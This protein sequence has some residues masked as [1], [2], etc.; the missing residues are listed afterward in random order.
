MVFSVYRVVQPKFLSFGFLYSLI[1]KLLEQVDFK[2][3]FSA[4]VHYSFTSLNK[5]ISYNKIF[6]FIFLIL[7][8]LPFERYI[9]IAMSILDKLYLFQ[10][11]L[12]LIYSTCPS[13]ASENII[14][15]AVHGHSFYP[16]L[17]WAIYFIYC[18]V[19]LLFLP[20]FSICSNQP[21]LN[22][23][24]LLVPYLFASVT[25]SP[26]LPACLVLTKCLYQFSFL[27]FTLYS[28]S[29]CFEFSFFNALLSEIKAVVINIYII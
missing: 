21:F 17:S 15:F 28:N 22:L 1:K 26:S 9:F 19:F 6:V 25:L 18:R 27:L 8:F 16:C 10:V 2:R 5:I 20:I 23:P 24:V 7:I 29:S 12:L 14:L 11:L 4:F 13:S 3:F